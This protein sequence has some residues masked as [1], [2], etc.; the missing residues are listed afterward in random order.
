M[1]YHEHELPLLAADVI[2]VAL[3][4]LGP[5]GNAEDGLAFLAEQLRAWGERRVRAEA[6]HGNVH[7][8]LVALLQTRRD[9]AA[10]QLLDALTEE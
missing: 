10:G 7:T 4:R 5:S 6:V 3:R 2:D 1:R 8:L 9:A